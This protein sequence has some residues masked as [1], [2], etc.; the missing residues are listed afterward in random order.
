MEVLWIREVL[1]I[2]IVGPQSHNLL[3]QYKL[4]YCQ[5]AYDSG[6]YQAVSTTNGHSQRKGELDLCN[7]KMQPF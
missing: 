1:W 7:L 3:F 6:K 5:N 4:Q 2:S